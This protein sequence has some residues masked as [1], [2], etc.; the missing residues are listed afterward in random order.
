MK[1]VLGYLGK[2]SMVFAFATLLMAANCEDT[3]PANTSAKDEQAQTEVNQQGL[4]SISKNALFLRAIS[5]EVSAIKQILLKSDKKGKSSK[6]RAGA[7]DFFKA[8]DKILLIDVGHYE[9]EQFTKNLLV[10]ILTKK[11]PN[12]AIILSQKNTNPIYYL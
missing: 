4:N 7:L 8:E 11:F 1:K 9:S 12:F 2:L 5:K 6:V 3:R 10:E